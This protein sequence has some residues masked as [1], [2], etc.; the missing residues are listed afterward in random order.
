MYRAIH[1]VPS[2]ISIKIVPRRIIIY[3]KKRL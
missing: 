1:A 2:C 3:K